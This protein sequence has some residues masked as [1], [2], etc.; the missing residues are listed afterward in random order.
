MTPESSNESVPI[1]LLDVDGVLNAVCHPSRPPQTWDHW[2]SGTA[3]AAGKR[4]AITFSPDLMAGI[5]ELHESGVVEIRWLTTWAHDANR[6]LR[7]LLELPEFPVAGEPVYAGAWWKLPCAVRAAEAERPLIW[8]DDDLDAAVTAR[9]WA[10][11]TGVLAI[12]PHPAVGLI[13]ADLDAIRTFCGQA[14]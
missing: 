10:A 1:W 14:A 11:D 13:P 2:R 8:T 3:V 12:A 4:F 6:S 5:R 9:R 7:E